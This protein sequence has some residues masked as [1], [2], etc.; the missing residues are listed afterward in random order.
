MRRWIRDAFASTGLF[1][2]CAPDGDEASDDF[3]GPVAMTRAIREACAGAHL[4][5][6][7]PGSPRFSQAFKPEP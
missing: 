3:D 4:L 7:A 2:A 6:A 1:V 5:A